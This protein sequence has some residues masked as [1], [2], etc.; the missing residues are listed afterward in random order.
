MSLLRSFAP[1]SHKVVVGAVKGGE[2]KK[3]K[4]IGMAKFIDSVDK[5]RFELRLWS[6]DQKKFY[7]VKNLKNDNYTIFAK[8]KEEASLDCPE[9]CNPVGYGYINKE[10][11]DYLQLQMNFPWQKIFLSLHP[12]F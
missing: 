1:T 10:F 9:F 11:K 5:K 4:Q 12:I 2:I 3:E 6:L 7:V 8:Q